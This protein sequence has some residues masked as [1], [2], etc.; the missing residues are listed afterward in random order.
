MFGKECVGYVRD[1]EGCR[2]AL[3]SDD[4][5]GETAKAVW[6]SYEGL[7]VLEH[8]AFWWCVAG[9]AVTGVLNLAVSFFLAFRVAMGSR[10]IRLA[11]RSRIRRAILRR[12]VSQPMS[13]VLPPKHLG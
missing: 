10:G 6:I 12:L 2:I 8:S 11:D 13:F 5:Y 3:S 9:I 1:A 4:N 7:S